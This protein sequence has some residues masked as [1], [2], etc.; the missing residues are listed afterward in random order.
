MMLS[1]SAH[2]AK[3][4]RARSG[5]TIQSLFLA[6]YLR[7][8]LQHSYLYPWRLQKKQVLPH[9]LASVIFTNLIRGIIIDG[10]L[11]GY[12][13]IFTF[14]HSLEIPLVVQAMQVDW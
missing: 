2:A 8:L 10:R 7:F 11:H 13:F 12:H 3:R 1:L 4:G 6:I 14:T 5:A 9:L